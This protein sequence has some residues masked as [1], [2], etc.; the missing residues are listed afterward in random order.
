MGGLKVKA[1]ARQKQMDLCV[2]PLLRHS[3]T[4]PLQLGSQFITAASDT[5]VGLGSLRSTCL[6]RPLNYRS[7]R[8]ALRHLSTCPNVRRYPHL[9]STDGETE[10]PERKVR[11]EVRTC[12]GLATV[13]APS[14]PPCLE[15]QVQVQE[16]LIGSAIWAVRRGEPAPL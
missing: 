6:A 14:L 10:S 4:G 13:G 5:E 8:T 12:A 2:H 15:R 9:P 7:P 3:R 16:Q 1:N 11:L